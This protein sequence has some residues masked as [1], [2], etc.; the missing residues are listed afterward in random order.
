MR[1]ARVVVGGRLTRQTYERVG[2]GILGKNFFW[3]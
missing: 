2:R 1:L 3:T